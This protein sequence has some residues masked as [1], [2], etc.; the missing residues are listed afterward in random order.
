MWTKELAQNRPAAQLT[1]SDKQL[2]QKVSPPKN[3]SHRRLLIIDKPERTQTQINLGQIGVLM[4]DPNYFPLHL[5]NYAFGGASFSSTLMVEIRVKKGWSYGANSAFR[6]GLQPRSWLVHLFPAAKDTPPALH[7]TLSLIKNLQEQ[8]IRQEK[9]D[10]AQRSLVNS[11]GFMYN[12]PQKRVENK[13]LEK[14]LDLPEGFMKS[15]GPELNQLTLSQ[16][17]EALKQFVKPDE[18][19]ITV[20]GTAKDLKSK[21]AEASGVPENQVDVKPYTQ[22]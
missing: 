2:L 14:T 13:L 7:E 21:L 18:L 1:A 8:G 9:F 10:F 16:V 4:T 3:T 11:A 12:T 22:D 19:A 5:G 6:F 17:N 15:F 20:L